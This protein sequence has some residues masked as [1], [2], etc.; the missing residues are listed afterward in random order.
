MK[1]EKGTMGWLALLYVL[2]LLGAVLTLEFKRLTIKPW[3]PA[4]FDDVTEHFKYGSIGAEV[5]GYP[6]LIW[7]ELPE[8]FKDELPGGYAD[9]GFLQEEGQE[10]PIGVSVRRYGVQR[11]GFNCATCHTDQV[12]VAGEPR[13]IMGAPANGL[14][15]Q[16]YIRFLVAA[17][18]DPRLTPDAVFESAE[19]NGRPFN[20]FNKLAFRYVVFNRLEE[21]VGGLVTSLAWMDKRPDHG[22][23]RTDAGNF[24]RARWGLAPEQDGLVGAVD[25]P[26]VWNQGIREDGWFHWDGNNASLTERNIS[27]ALAGGASEW[28][29]EHS[30]VERVAD[31]LRDL[32][33]PP[34]PGEIDQDLA[35]R[36]E[37]IYRETGCGACH[38]TGSVKLGQV[39]HQDLLAT[40]TARADLFSPKMVEYFSNVGRGYSYQF[41]NYRSTEGY[42]N[43]PLDGIWARGPYLHNGSVPNL[44]DLLEK[45]SD[46]T[47]RFYRG[48]AEFDL[49][50]VGPDCRTGFRFDAAL[51]GNS[52]SGHVYGTD[53]PPGEKRALIE[54]LKGL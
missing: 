9:F 5:D 24:W 17:S 52:N 53:L 31:W 11:V 14:D 26:S 18:R 45:P 54:Y 2:V 30:S 50:R 21:E 10:L 51:P 34:F 12:M 13:L 28:L 39:T 4:H 23:G 8:I 20:W 3:P 35:A 41:S 46:R 36:G 33:P 49:D 32:P 44:A 6:Y 15:L 27:A 37:Q 42:V 38:D 40:D 25:F 16:A 7:R 1:R 47:A 22:P 43:A 29:F 19:K 48:C